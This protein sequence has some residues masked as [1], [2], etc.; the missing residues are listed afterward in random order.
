[1]WLTTTQQGLIYYEMKNAYEHNAR[2]LWIVN[3]HDLKPAAYDLELFLDM[4][5]NINAVGLKTTISE[6][7]KKW[8]KREFGNEAGEKLFP[9]MREFYRLTAIR[10][11]EF[12]GWNQVELDK[13]KYARGMSPVY[14]TEFSFKEFNS[15]ADRYLN[16]YKMIKEIIIDAEKIIPANKKDAIFAAIKYPVFSAS[17]MAEKILEAQRARSIASGG[18][19]ECRWKRDDPL[20]E[21]CIKSMDAYY[22]IRNL[23]NYYNDELSGGKWKYSMCFNPRDLFVFD[24]PTLPM[25]ITEKEINK[26]LS[27]SKDKTNISTPIIS[28][29]FFIARNASSFT[30]SSTLVLPIKMLGHSMNAV[31]LK[32]GES[33][34]Y[35][36][37]SK[38]EGNAVLRTAVIPAHPSDKG[39]IRFSVQM[40]NEKPQVLS[41]KENGR[42]ET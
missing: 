37:E 36:F 7:L 29:D 19:D 14:E 11:P 6:H 39:D 42:T 27:S 15:E 40:D 25:G 16:D 17:A 13:K 20:M 4:A 31:P 41:F 5:W 8:L 9:A 34:I 28:D 18:Y 23:T 26:F 35:H 3:V 2:R 12:M 30:N 21:A 32:K 22:R 38:K 24:P 1:M 10:K 33:L